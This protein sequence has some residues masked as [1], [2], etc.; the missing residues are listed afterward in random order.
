MWSRLMIRIG[1]LRIRRIIRDGWIFIIIIRSN[2]RIIVG[3]L[4]Y[5]IV[6]MSFVLERLWGSSNR[7]SCGD[8]VGCHD[9]GDGQ[10]SINVNVNGKENVNLCMNMNMSMRTNITKKHSNDNSI[11]TYEKDESYKPKLTRVRTLGNQST[12]KYKL[13]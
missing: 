3:Y 8:G 1:L 7:G 12:K 2:R 9:G 13:R 5:V 6:Q 4:C 11:I 10:R